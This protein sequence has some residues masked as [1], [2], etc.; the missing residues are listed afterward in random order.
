MGF[1]PFEL[2]VTSSPLTSQEEEKKL[3]NVFEKFVPHV[4][5]EVIICLAPI[6]NLSNIG[7][8]QSWQGQIVE[9]LDVLRRANTYAFN[10]LLLARSLKKFAGIPRE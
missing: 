7:F 1:P 6:Y 4:I 2:R 8:E 5:S 3:L 10:F 9:L